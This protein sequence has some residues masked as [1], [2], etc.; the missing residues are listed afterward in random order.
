[1]IPDFIFQH[2]AFIA[3]VLFILTVIFIVISAILIE[4]NDPLAGVALI[5]I[6][7]LL[8]PFTD[9]YDDLKDCLKHETLSECKVKTK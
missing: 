2:W 8:S 5:I 7:L 6:V 3:P 4:D 9:K 1:M